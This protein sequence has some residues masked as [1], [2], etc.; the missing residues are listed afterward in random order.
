VISLSDEVAFIEPVMARAESPLVLVGHHTVPQW[1]VAALSNPERVRALAIYEPTLFSLVDA[2]SPPPNEADGIGRVVADA[3]ASL[4]AGDTYAAAERFIDFWMTPGTWA[5]TPEQRKAPIAASIKNIRRWAHALF[6]EP[7]PLAA[8]QSLDVPVL[9]M[10]GE[11][12]PDSS[13]AVARLLTGALPNVEVV[14][15][16]SSAWDRLSS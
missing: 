4:D 14:E 2:V 9:Y 1:L 3:V 13:R 8:F 16:R 11:R 5:L 10:V 7:T 15:L 6:T 12:S